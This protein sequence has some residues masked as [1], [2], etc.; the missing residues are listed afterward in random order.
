[1]CCC[2]LTFCSCIGVQGFDDPFLSFMTLSY[3]LTSF[4]ILSHPALSLIIRSYTLSP[5][6]I[7]YHSCLS[8]LVLAYR[9]SS[10]LIID[11][12]VL[13]FLILV[14]LSHSIFSLLCFPTLSCLSFIILSYLWSTF[15]LLFIPAF[16]SQWRIWKG[17]SGWRDDKG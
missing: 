11:H 16:V 2:V 8:F 14:T 7:L 3:L 1:M 10:C 15:L 6:L 5:F 9:W 17:G 4:L 13:T 12:P